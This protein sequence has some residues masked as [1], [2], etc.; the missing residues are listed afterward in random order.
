MPVRCARSALIACLL[1]AVAFAA[2]GPET[3]VPVRWDGGP[4]EV[5]RR[6]NDKNQN[7]ELSDP[8]VREAISEWYDPATL[9]LLEDTPFNCLL[10]TLSAGGDPAIEQQQRQLVVRYAGAARGRNLK[11]LG[12][13]YPGADPVAAA[14]AAMDAQLDGLVLE[15]DFPGTFAAQLDATL[16]AKKSAVI[17]IPLVQPAVA[18]K[19]PAPVVAVAG[20]A[21]A[22]GKPSSDVFTASATAGMW[23]DSNLWLV[24]AFYPAENRRPVWVD[25]A[26]GGAS[27]GI[28][29]KSIADAAAAGGRWI[30]SLDDTLRPKL[31]HRDAEALAVWR[32]IAAD[33]A[34][35]Q[36]RAQWKGF[37]P[38]G[39]V[40]IIVDTAGKNL[41]NSE[42]YLNLVARRQIP[43]RVIYRSG[44]G[45]DSLA[46]LRAVLAL[47]LSPPTVAE[48]TILRAF[49][50]QGGL[51][52]SGPSWGGGP[53]DQSYTVLAVE[54]GEVAVYK[55]E[56]PDPES[57]ARDLNDLLSTPDFGVSVFNAPSVVPY[58][59]S[60]DGGKRMLIQL[61]NYASRPAE[62]VVVWLS[63]RFNSARLYSADG[64]AVDLP[65][66]RSGSRTEIAIAKLADYGALL[67]E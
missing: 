7:K 34:F 5:A 2:G 62:S 3:W 15:G 30:V 65:V 54:Q 52:L 28:Y 38:V 6:A 20:V 36:G 59:S 48:R 24:R 43:Y 13:V 37:A 58:V 8:A 46:G 17:L 32:S 63:G 39:N 9:T 29:L 4:L 1:A 42:E 21:P 26:P 12:V 33:L 64:A 25:H 56:S 50:A 45:A 16:H 10:L 55:D 41:A 31:L 66:K 60:P 19:T 44:L 67:V 18:W 61:L 49:A 40:G 23:V 27:P 53:K 35:F 47:D 11:V 51:V 22:V 14:S 57:V